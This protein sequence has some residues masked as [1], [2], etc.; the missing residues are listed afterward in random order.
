MTTATSPQNNE[1]V[2]LAVRTNMTPALNPEPTRCCQ[3]DWRA[4]CLSL[5]PTHSSRQTSGWKYKK[6]ALTFDV[7]FGHFVFHTPHEQ[8]HAGIPATPD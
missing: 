8:S 4:H 3:Y 7:A 5:S 6:A 2:L 1:L